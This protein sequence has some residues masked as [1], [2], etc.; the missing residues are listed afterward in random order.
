LHVKRELLNTPV[1]GS[2]E[3]FLSDPGVP[4]SRSQS[5]R[6][7]FGVGHVRYVHIS[8]HILGLFKAISVQ[9]FSLAVSGDDEYKVARYGI[10]HV[11]NRVAV[12]LSE[13]KFERIKQDSKLLFTG[14][15]C[16]KALARVV[17]ALEVPELDLVIHGARG[18]S[19]SSWVH[20]QRQDSL[21]AMRHLHF[22]RGRNFALQGL[23]QTNLVLFAE[24]FKSF[25][26]PH[27]RP[28]IRHRCCQLLVALVLEA[29]VQKLHRRCHLHRRLFWIQSLAQ[30]CLW[31]W[32][33]QSNPRRRHRSLFCLVI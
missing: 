20:G 2:G 21:R 5:G 30:E 24:I 1:L 9:Y 29:W 27:L 19:R 33:V 10:L 8:F 15:H 14:S 13:L 11:F 26:I 3:K 18:H 23:K 12:E 17:H 4:D 7:A 22:V 28:Q 31:E 32:A 25:V 6:V 16:S